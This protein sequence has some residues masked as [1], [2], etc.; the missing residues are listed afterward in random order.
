MYPPKPLK[1]NGRKKINKWNR[2]SYHCF[3]PNNS[4][5]RQRGAACAPSLLNILYIAT[6]IYNC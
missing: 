2:L 4:L 1:A 5:R 6:C 3:S